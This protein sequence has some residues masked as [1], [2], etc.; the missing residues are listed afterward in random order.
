VN[1]A[2]AKLDKQ[3]SIAKIITSPIG[4]H[5]PQVRIFDQSGKLQGQFYAYSRLFTGGVNVSAMAINE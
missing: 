3:S 5:S 2:T 1:V 4:A